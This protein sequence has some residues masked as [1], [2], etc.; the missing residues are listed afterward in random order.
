MAITLDSAVAALNRYSL[1][2]NTEIIQKQRQEL[3][4][5]QEFTLQPCE[6][7][8]AALNVEQTDMIQAFQ[9]AFTAKG[10]TSFSG[11]EFKLQQMKVDIQY[12]CADLEKFFESYMVE[13][14]EP[15]I[16]RTEWGFPKWWYANVY[17]PK[18]KEE[19]ELS[20]AYNGE[21]VAPTSGTAGLTINACDGLG[22]VIADAIDDSKLTP[23][24]VGSFTAT[25]YVDVVNDFISQL[26][27]LYRNKGGRIYMAPDH[28]RGYAA[29][30]LERYKTTVDPRTMVGEKVEFPVPNSNFMLVGLPSMVGKN[31][32]IYSGRPRN[33]KVGVRRGQPMVP[34]IRWQ[35]FERTLKGL[36]EFHRFYGVDYWPELF[37]SDQE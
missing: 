32:M 16:E 33:I 22:T 19:M 28:V 36:S 24:A 5:E 21:H 31:R 10:D 23:I 1:V 4:T 18:W 30:F 34:V 26:P 13:W 8:Y 3:V 7:S 2:Y 11:N 27:F 37:V 9:C 29:D 17:L 6:N 12:S 35:V 25:T 15:G 20:V 14:Y